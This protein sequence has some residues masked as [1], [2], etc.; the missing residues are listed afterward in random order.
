V[1][2]TPAPVPTLSGNGKP[3]AER[4]A[5]FTGLIAP[6]PTPIYWRDDLTIDHVVIGPAVIEQEDA[7]TVVYP[8]QRAVRLPSGG[9]FVEREETR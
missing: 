3:F 8:G 5:F 2:V 1:S 7:T 9:L 4:Q 6:V